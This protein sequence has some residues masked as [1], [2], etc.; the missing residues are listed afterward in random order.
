MKLLI[1]S[2]GAT[3]GTKDPAPAGVGVVLREPGK[4]GFNP[5]V[6]VISEPIGRTSCT[7][8]EYLAV[9]RALGEAL[10]LGASE[11]ELNCDCL[12]LVQQIQGKARCLDE[13]VARRRREVLQLMARF[14]QC[15]VRHVYSCFNRDADRLAKRAAARSR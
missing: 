10:S 2:D 15:E 1:H 8:A 11:V 3:R 5:L 9:L 12:V 14:E 4:G 13:M 6:S 7:E